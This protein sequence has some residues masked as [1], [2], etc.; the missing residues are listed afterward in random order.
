MRSKVPEK[1]IGCEF[2]EPL[3]FYYDRDLGEKITGN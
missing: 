1:L 3:R 2:F